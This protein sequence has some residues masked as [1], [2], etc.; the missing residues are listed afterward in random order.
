MLL[1][2]LYLRDFA[3][4]ECVLVGVGVDLLLLLSVIVGCVLC[5]LTFFFV[6]LF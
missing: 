5:F 2:L 6:S 3:R 1:L 4:G